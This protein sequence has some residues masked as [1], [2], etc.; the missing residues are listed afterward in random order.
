MNVPIKFK[1]TD[2]YEARK[3]KLIK[4]FWKGSI[5]VPS[6]DFLL[7]INFGILTKI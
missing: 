5:H 4:Y 1:I 3:L 7:I 6:P 2:S